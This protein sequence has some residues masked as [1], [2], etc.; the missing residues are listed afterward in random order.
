MISWAPGRLPCHSTT[1]GSGFADEKPTSSLSLSTALFPWQI[2][3]YQVLDMAASRNRRQIT[4]KLDH[5]AQFCASHQITQVSALPRYASLGSACGCQ[6]CQEVAETDIISSSCRSEDLNWAIIFGDF[7]RCDS[8]RLNSGEANW[9]KSP[10]P[11]NCHSHPAARILSHVP[12]T[13]TYAG[14]Y[15]RPIFTEKHEHIDCLRDIEKQT[16]SLDGRV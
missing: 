16:V 10:D 3:L 1:G 13:S 7:C 8:V 15:R 9:V 4:R 14:L 2:S 11:G 5:G 12:C 6:I